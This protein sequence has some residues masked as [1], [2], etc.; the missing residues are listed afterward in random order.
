MKN[1]FKKIFDRCNNFAR[2]NDIHGRGESDDYDKFSLSALRAKSVDELGAMLADDTLFPIDD[3]G[4]NE[5]IDRITTVIIEKKNIPEK[6]LEAR[7]RAI[8]EGLLRRH[9]DTI[10]IR[11]EDVTKKRKKPVTPIAPIAPIANEEQEYS[12]NE[13]RGDR[14][15]FGMRRAFTAAA[16]VAVFVLVGNT[17]TTVAYG[18]NILQAAANFTAELF[19]TDYVEYKPE[20]TTEITT[21]ETTVT[22][23]I[24]TTAPEFA[25]YETL[26]EAFDAFG[27]TSQT[28][29]TWLPE[30]YEP[31]GVRAF[32][33]ASN[34][35]IS[36]SYRNGDDT[37]F[38]AIISYK[39]NSDSQT[40][41]SERDYEPD[42]TFI[43]GGTRY[44]IFDYYYFTN[45]ARN[46]I[47][48][49]DEIND[50]TLQGNI[51]IDDMKKIVKSMNKSEIM[52]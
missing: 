45:S 22:Q 37:F 32:G 48:W 39:E 50:F 36:S 25:V 27:I 12:L 9:G 13:V 41:Y 52:D 38:I 49:S 2:K 16:A 30:G 19:R 51:S 20:I 6:E 47:R 31:F 46:T 14:R 11:L 5:I 43:Y 1:I 23:T 17:I 28:A 18:T 29:P 4:N 42:E 7:R 10:P 40:R 34:P 3:E 33:S 44:Y 26:Q 35:V 8:W 21:T 24:E 15:R